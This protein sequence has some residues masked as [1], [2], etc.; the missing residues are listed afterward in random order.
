MTTEQR[1]ILLTFYAAACAVGRLVDPRSQL[2]RAVRQVICE[3]ERSLELAPSQPS[4]AARH[5]GQG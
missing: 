5:A 1:A 3:L 2:H 4:R